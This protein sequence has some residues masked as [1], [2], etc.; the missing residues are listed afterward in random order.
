MNIGVIVEGHGEFEAVPLLVRRIVQ[1]LDPSFDLKVAQPLR[2]AKGQIVKE[3]ELKRAVELIARKSGPGSPILVVLDADDD[4]ACRL[5]PQLAQWTRDARPDRATG[6]VVAVREYEAW[7]LAA[8]RSLAGRRG[9]PMDLKPPQ[10][11]ERL[12]NPKR[13]L[14]DRMANG[15]SETL[16]QPALTAVMSLEEARRADSFDKLVRDLARLTGCTPPPRHR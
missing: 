15:Y 8:A 16:D 12:A 9:L 6:V 14:D 2:I 4:A 5:G 11:P 10:E 13:W 7:F 3:P 1:W